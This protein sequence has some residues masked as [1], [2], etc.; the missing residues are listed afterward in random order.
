VRIKK[1]SIQG[2]KSFV[3]KVVLN[4]AAEPAAIIGPNGCGKSNIIDAIRWVTGEQNAR[5]LRGK[6]MEDIISNGSE[7]RKP[8]GMAEVILTFTNERG[9]APSRF[10]GFSEIE[11]AR[12]LYRSGESEYYI[13]KVKCR[14]RD[15]AELFT[16]TGI[17][18]QGYSIVEQGQVSWLINARPEERR[19]LFEE[20]A[21]INKFKNKRDTALRRLASTKDNLL[22]VSDIISEVKRQLNSLNRQAKKAERYRAAKEALKEVD[23]Q[24]TSLEYSLLQAKRLENEKKIAEAEDLGAGLLAEG[25]RLESGRDEAQSDLAGVEAR[26]KVIEETVYT[27]EKTLATEEREAEVA[28]IRSEELTRNNTRLQSEIAEAE[29][30]KGA[31]ARG[32]SETE[33][34]LEEAGVSLAERQRE[35]DLLFTDLKAAELELQGRRQVEGKLKAS[36]VE[37]TARLSNIKFSIQTAI[38]D[39]GRER[40]REAKTG[41][42]ILNARQRIESLTEPL[43]LLQQDVA[44]ST[45]KGESLE[46]SILE[47]RNRL[48]NLEGRKHTLNNEIDGGKESRAADNARLSTLL[49]MEKNLENI[50]G[51]ARSI[52]KEG[53]LQGIHGIIADY[54][55]TNPGYEKAVEAALAEKLEYVIV[56]SQGETLDAIGFLKTNAGGRGSFVPVHD[57]RPAP[58]AVPA[59]YAANN[60]VKAISDEIK[61]RDGYSHIVKTLLGDTIIAQDL[62][63]AIDIWRTEGLFKTIVTLDGERLSPE[64]VITG[65]GLGASDGGILQR[66]GEIKAI[67]KSLSLLETNL[68]VLTGEMTDLEEKIASGRHELDELTASLHRVEIKQVNTGSE[69]KRRENELKTLREL[70]QNLE[71]ENNT[72][73]EALL[74]IAEKNKSLQRERGALEESLS[75]NDK[76]LSRLGEETSLIEEKKTAISASVTASKIE[77]ARVT[78]RS[79][80]LETRRGD[81]QRLIEELANLFLQRVNEKARSEAEIEE[82]KQLSLTIKE[83]IENL[84]KELSAAK[85]GRTVEKEGL[86]AVTE[87]IHK[88]DGAIR[89]L[90]D[91]SRK[92]EEQ[93]GTLG[94]GL[95]EIEMKVAGLEEKMAERY[96]LSLSDLTR[97]VSEDETI[98]DEDG[99]K[100]IE[101]ANPLALREQRDEIRAKIISMGEV[102]LSAL[103][104]YRELEE[105]HT[106]LLKQHEDLTTS[107]EGL[108]KAIAR[109]NKT[110]RAMFS[111]AFKE[112]NEKFTEN[113][114]KFFRG[115]HAELRLLDESNILESGIEIVAQ[116]PGKKLQ[117]L[118]LLSGGEKALT[119]VSLIFSIF[120][121]KPS[122]FCLLDEVDAPLDEANIDRFN[123][124]VRDISNISQFILITHN[125]R[126]MEMVD[127]LYGITM[128]EPGVSKVVSVKF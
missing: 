16:D 9:K 24:L 44:Q 51:G 94:F 114:P 23:L 30:K 12:R 102:S 60:G 73:T 64:G 53:K 27:L 105:R 48:Q 75:V 34:A 33:R 70:Q 95:K 15:V 45:E 18:K 62:N 66:R 1:L 122:P 79:G 123:T 96:G 68:G 76:E 7:S 115:G 59:G 6:N 50:H 25:A 20:A 121:I 32:L 5:H 101:V 87:S 72:A 39:E 100:A 77:L 56:E 61:I 103:E 22:R 126:T 31:A 63:E 35:L 119:A 29:T 47:L 42:G 19:V 93:K 54:I 85:E 106:F 58:S 88:A 46:S 41:A 14:L 108:H 38:K 80:A 67:K 65:G 83:K 86:Q 125:K 82:K 111:A 71:S 104:E 118:T 124:F 99:E 49:E 90:E 117:N 8:V 37:E 120:L 113:F 3:D 78:E 26:Y 36:L 74:A 109:I 43:A 112:I 91:K 128:E 84:Y 28:R 40:E 21:G 81:Q 89:A 4:L 97:P 116:P 11:V 13:N 55:D 10:A 107:M 110:T 98:D 2:F 92:L 57:L 69:I 52:L 17:G 127:R